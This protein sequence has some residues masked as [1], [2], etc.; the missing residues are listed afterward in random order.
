MPLNP[1][2]SDIYE[3]IKIQPADASSSLDFD[4]FI[5]PVFEDELAIDEAVEMISINAS[6]LESLKA[7]LAHEGFLGKAGDQVITHLSI[8]NK[9]KTFICL[10][11]GNK[12]DLNV[13]V[14]RKL[15][16][17]LFSDL[18]KYKNVQLC[19]LFPWFE[20]KLLNAVFDATLDSFVRT[21]YQFNEFKTTVKPRV[22]QALSFVAKKS[23]VLREL[24]P[25]MMA[26]Q[27]GINTTKNL[28]NLPANVCTPDY[29]VEQC[30]YLATKFAKI[31]TTI[32]KEQELFDLN[33]HS[34]LAVN[35][36]S[37]YEAT[38][39]VMQYRGADEN[40]APIVVI[41]K[42]VTFDTGGI[43]I[44]GA[45]GMEAMIYD[46][47]GA[48]SAFGL[49]HAVASMDLNI[50][51]IV[52]L[53]TAENCV[54]GRAYRPGDVIETMSGQTVEVISTDA[55][56]RLLLCDAISYAKC[57]NPSYVVD[58]ATL[59]GAAIVSLGHQASGLMSNDDGLLNEL[60]NSGK[61]RHD[62]AWAFPLWP[63]YMETLNSSCADMKNTGSNSPGM[64][65]AGC[66]LSKFA[67]GIR[68]AHLDIAG[69]SFKYGK[70]NT[71]TGRPLP[72][73]LNFMVQ[74]ANALDV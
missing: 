28:A 54:D 60:I 12:N 73:L 56:G 70:Q 10:G 52:I 33:M 1:T 20:T 3:S 9:I 53:A 42:G 15:Y 14:L 24:L 30:E 27:I 18:M 26:E 67:K 51:L 55:E 41:G 5:L 34:Y 66:F 47:A 44:K 11:I 38:M 19:V 59:T 63:E 17:G 49:M 16:S 13:L 32:I 23:E 48:A 71:A 61:K 65:T 22:K 68:W 74:K 4:C 40:I 39:P 25:Q 6:S 64:V 50:N 8:E 36:A 29:L 62:R 35:R 37:S 45:A 43:S 46:M 69:T 31:T 2:E 72:L 7:I 57:F 58:L 21:H